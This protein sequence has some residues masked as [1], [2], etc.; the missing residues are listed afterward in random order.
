MLANRK[1]D[2]P[3]DF[4][5][6]KLT[7]VTTEGKSNEIDKGTFLGFPNEEGC[8]ECSTDNSIASSNFAFILVPERLM[9]SIENIPSPCQ[10]FPVPS[11]EVDVNFYGVLV[12]TS[13][14]DYHTK[15]DELYENG[16]LTHVLRE[17]T[18]NEIH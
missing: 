1:E 16:L 12:E 10:I 5:Y 15:L 8:N 18:K 6:A 4:G 9:P 17:K 3:N 14:P 11:T 13:A 2:N 7:L